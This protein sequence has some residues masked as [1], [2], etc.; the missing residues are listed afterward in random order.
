MGVWERANRE[1]SGKSI[2][3]D[4]YVQI[5]GEANVLQTKRTKPFQESEH[6]RLR[7]HKHKGTIIQTPYLSESS[8]ADYQ[9]SLLNFPI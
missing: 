8:T 6:A 2:L 5:E 3:K 1:D 9:T 7:P 4:T